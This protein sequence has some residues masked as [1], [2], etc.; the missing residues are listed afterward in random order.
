MQAE[1]RA[2]LRAEGA[3][4]CLVVMDRRDDFGRPDLN[5]W[6][7]VERRIGARVPVEG[8]EVQW[9]PR[10]DVIDLRDGAWLG[11]VVEVSVT[12]ATIDA[13]STLPVEVST[14][15]ILRYG[16][17]ESTVM[18]RHASPTAQP[19][20]TRFGIEWSHLEDPL[21]RVVFGV[22]ADAK[23]LHSPA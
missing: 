12:G 18:V 1:T 6:H 13:A 9:L 19:G 2:C 8:I 14:Q 21:R 7:N 23:S 16:T 3:L 22:V 15:V 17:G 4:E 11:R 20:V 5:A 10:T